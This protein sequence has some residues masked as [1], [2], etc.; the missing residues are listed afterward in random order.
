MSVKSR[1]ATDSEDLRRAS[2][3]ALKVLSGEGEPLNASALLA[4]TPSDPDVLELAQ[5]RGRIDAF[6]LRVRYSNTALHAR[7]SPPPGPAEKLFTLLE[8][9]RV[10]ALGTR[11]MR[12]VRANLAALQ[13]AMLPGLRS[14]AST[15]QYTVL[16]AARYRFGAPLPETVRDRLRDGRPADLASEAVRRIERMAALL[17]D[18]AAFA[19]EARALAESSAE[20]P[21]ERQSE[22]M[23]DSAD[24]SRDQAQLAEQAAAPMQPVGADTTQVGI[25]RRVRDEP[26]GRVIPRE[27]V[28]TAGISSYHAYTKQFDDVLDA[29]EICEPSRMATLEQE[30][31]SHRRSTQQSIGRWAHRL[32]RHLL[33]RQ[34]RTWQF[35]REEGLLDCARLTRVITDPLQSLSFK[36]ETE[37]DFPLTA[38]M[39]LV[40]NSGSMRGPPIATAAACAQ[41]LGTVLERCGVRSEILGFT[42]RRWRGGRTRERWLADGRP[43]DPG[44]LTDLLHIVYKRFDSPWRRARRHLAAMLDDT[45]LKENV[46]GEALLWAHDR[47]LRRPEPRRILMVISD[48]APLDDATLSANDFGYLDRHLRQVIRQIQHNSPVEL[49]AIGI[50]HDVGAYYP[51]ALTVSGPEDLGEAMVS[52]LVELLS[53]ARKGSLIHSIKSPLRATPSVVRSWDSRAVPKEVAPTHLPKRHQE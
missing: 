32:Q 36:Q 6:A 23:R 45:L 8:Q 40:D 52:K 18:Q 13:A 33:A 51:R 11:G 25:L 34:M 27:W 17:D 47:L 53:S 21:V 5:W 38:V 37:A 1:R 20:P 10:E 43:E 42:T 39:V 26:R 46:D 16:V 19:T 9:S 31:I 44:R 30:L 28:P 12:G 49:I 29:T 14:T 2:L 48:G 35:D 3:A 24:R 41:M 15:A 4:G 7:F 50:G 22:L